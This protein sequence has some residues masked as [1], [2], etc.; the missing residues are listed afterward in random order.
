MGFGALERTLYPINIVTQGYYYTGKV[1]PVGPILIWF[2]DP[3]RH[4]FPVSEVAATA[5]D[6]GSAVDSFTRDDIFM[7]KP[8]VVVVDVVSP[9]A[10]KQ[11]QLIQH[12]QK[13]VVYTARF[14]IN[15]SFPCS[16]DSRMG[17]M[18]DGLKGDFVP[19]TG[20]QVYPIRPSRAPVFRTS[21]MIILNTRFITAYHAA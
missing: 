3:E 11:V 7:L 17:D 12:T 8:D 1:S 19:L 9:E 21:E 18:F 5:L 6:G 13:L 4:A 16:A 10:R 2:N 14:V 20:A 15:A